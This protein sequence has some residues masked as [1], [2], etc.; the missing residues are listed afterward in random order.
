MEKQRLFR[1]MANASPDSLKELSDK[2]T[3]NHEVTIVKE[4]SKTL[5]MIKM[6]E[7]VKS[8]LFYI[9][10]VMVSEAIVEMDGIKGTAVTMGDDFLKVLSMAI[11]DSGF[12]NGFW[13]MKEIEVALTLLEA[14]QIEKKERENALHLKTMVSFNT[15]S[16]V[17]C[18][19]E[20]T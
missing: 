8:S 13:V 1:I 17:R 18:N 14:K 11:I 10:E 20:N 9:G 7:P 19:E 4:P 16:E 5:T 3:Q 2:I 6:R 15:M 12:N